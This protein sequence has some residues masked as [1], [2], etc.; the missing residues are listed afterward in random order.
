VSARVLR[1]GGSQHREAERLLPW[2]VNGTLDADERAL[3]VAHLE[4]CIDC[5]RE[6]AQLHVLQQAC[7]VATPAIDPMPSFARLRLRLQAPSDSHGSPASRGARST[8]VSRWRGARSAWTTTPT[9]LRGMVAAQCALL[10]VLAGAWWAWEP[11]TPYRVLGNPP[12]AVT[13]GEARLVVV[14]AP[15]TSQVRMQ[16]LLRATGTHIVDGPNGVGAY[17]LTAPVARAASVRD[18][19]RAAPGVRMVESLDGEAPTP[20]TQ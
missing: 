15:E 7:T 2:L 20:A 14:F 6:L 11:P 10:L 4:S 5:Q 8:R 9:W 1:F 16:Q 19:L 12:A 13:P 18:A 3:V 17:V